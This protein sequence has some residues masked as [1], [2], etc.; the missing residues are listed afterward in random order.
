M[1]GQL[2]PGAVSAR[3]GLAV[4]AALMLVRG[5]QL[6]VSPFLGSNCRFVPSCSAY[7]SEA[8]ACH[9]LVRG[10]W[11]TLRRIGRCHPWGGSGYDPVPGCR[12]AASGG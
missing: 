7:T 3:P 4:R 10:G 6:L 12:E 11:L 9:G 8:L 2:N 5:Y 1:C